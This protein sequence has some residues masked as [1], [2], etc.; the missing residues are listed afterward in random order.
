[1]DEKTGTPDPI[2]SELLAL[3]KRIVELER[4]H[5]EKSVPSESPGFMVEEQA[6]REK[7]DAFLLDGLTS[8]TLKRIV[9]AA[10]EAL[11]SPGGNIGMLNPA[12]DLV[13]H[14]IVPDQNIESDESMSAPEQVTLPHAVWETVCG[15]TLLEGKALIQNV[16]TSFGNGSGPHLRSV[17][18]PI[19]YR[20]RAVGIL[21]AVGRIRD[22]SEADLGVLTRIA[23]HLGPVIGAHI[24]GATTGA[25]G[26]AD[27]DTRRFTDA[28]SGAAD[29]VWE[30][31]L[32]TNRFFIDDRFQQMLGIENGDRATEFSEW[33]S[34]VQPDQAE[35]VKNLIA[36]HLVGHLDRI[37]T[38]L[39]VRGQ[40]GQTRTVLFRG[41][42]FTDPATGTMR[43]AGLQTD[44]TGRPATEEHP[45]QLPVPQEKSE[46]SPDPETL[47]KQRLESLGTFASGIAH[48]INNPLNGILNYA[49]IISDRFEKDA[50]V[51]GFA[52]KILSESDRVASIVRGVQ[53]FARPD[54]TETAPASMAD[55]VD[56]TLGLVR[57][58][59][60]SVGIAVEV[61]AER[62]LPKVICRHQQVQQALMNLITNAAEALNRKYP[63]PSDEKK[64]TIALKSLTDEQGQWLRT[65]LTDHGDGIEPE[66]AEKIFD[67]FF[68]TKP[69][70]AGAGLGLWVAFG[71]LREHGGRLK[72]ES[73]PGGPTTVLMDLPSAGAGSREK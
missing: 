14:R 30:W 10:A 53:A 72:I 60:R 24:D 48:E 49:Q 19:P 40:D 42:S 22:Y 12:G 35:R 17:S 36:A 26:A 47:V 13:C 5:T 21:S 58:S 31:D 4:T 6:L 57:S 69:R 59:L 64:L 20:G 38:E 65:T 56:A 67:P 68:T 7:I 18:A 63:E 25:I 2:R 45:A 54:K 9:S 41:R 15:G 61:S 8:E 16:P 11:D 55:I 50:D 70:H 51:K 29:G 39:N 3:Q 34:W 27:A 37:E 23:T 52:Q 73:R 32:S 46:A 62:S 71:V 43:L 66:N 44:V 28:I 33:L 1:M